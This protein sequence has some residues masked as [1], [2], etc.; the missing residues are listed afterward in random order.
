MPYAVWNMPYGSTHPLYFHSGYGIFHCDSMKYDLMDHNEICRIPYENVSRT[1]VRAASLL[2]RR[3]L[4]ETCW[5]ADFCCD[6]IN[7][8]WLGYRAALLLVCSRLCMMLKLACFFRGQGRSHRGSRGQ[9]AP[10]DSEKVA[11][12]RGKEGKREHEEKSGKKGK[13]REGF[14]TLPF[15]ADSAGYATS[16]SSATVT[17]KPLQNEAWWQSQGGVMHHYSVVNTC[18]FK[19]NNH[20]SLFCLRT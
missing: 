1:L 10:P 3:N 13:N 17:S 11:K 5:G 20:R 8:D 19:E 6:G 7:V 16:C 2:S 12:N 9:S 4:Y 14:F 15:L 18:M